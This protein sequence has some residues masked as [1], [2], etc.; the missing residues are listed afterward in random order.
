MRTPSASATLDAL[1]DLDV[2]GLDL[3]PFRT[4]DGSIKGLNVILGGRGCPFGCTF[5][6]HEAWRRYG[7]RSVDAMIGD[8]VARHEQ[9]GIDTF[10]ISDETFS[11]QRPRVAEFCRRLIKEDLGFKWLAQTRVNCIDAELLEL[12]RRL[13]MQPDLFRRREC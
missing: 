5:C 6:S 2:T 1:G 11:V 9:Y 12:F 4:V 10:Y 3:Y 13:G 7:S 8:M